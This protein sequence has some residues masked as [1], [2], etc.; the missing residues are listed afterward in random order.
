MLLQSLL[1]TAAAINPPQLM[2][3]AEVDREILT[4]VGGARG[5]FLLHGPTHAECG[6]NSRK[7]ALADQVTRYLRL[8]K[9][10]V[11]LGGKP[12]TEYE[13]MTETHHPSCPRNRA[14]SAAQWESSMKRIDD[15]LVRMK[16]LLARKRQLGDR[17]TT[18]SSR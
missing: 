13:I 15:Q 1:L 12:P 14:K 3:M 11:A 16:A 10:F 17:S 8:E 4:M 7:R 5:G 9:D 18:A 2:P 6:I